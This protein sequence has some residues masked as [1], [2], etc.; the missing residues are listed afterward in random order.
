V[1]TLPNFTNK[2]VIGEIPLPQASE[3]IS[4]Y[5][6]NGHWYVTVDITKSLLKSLVQALIK[7]LR[8]HFSHQDIVYSNI[9]Y[10]PKRRHNEQT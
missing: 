2:H 4:V 10:L 9:I 7:V 6:N 8:A 5:C 3:A 1:K